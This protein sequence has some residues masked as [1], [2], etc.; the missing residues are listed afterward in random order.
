MK[1]RIEAPEL[2]MIIGAGAAL[3]VLLIGGAI[4]LYQLIQIMLVNQTAMGL[5]I[6]ISGFVIFAIGMVWYDIRHDGGGYP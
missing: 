2:L 4:G 6:F 5:G 1:D 3:T